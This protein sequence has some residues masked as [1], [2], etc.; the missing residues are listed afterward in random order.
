[1]DENGAIRSWNTQAEKIFGWPRK[2]VLGKDL[3]DLIV[4][5][6]DQGR[7]E[8]GAGNASSIPDRALIL[9]RR[10]ETPGAAARRQGV[11]GRTQRHRAEDAQRIPVQR[12]FSADLTE[13]IVAEERESGSS[14]KMEAIG[15]LHRR[16]RA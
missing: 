13:K 8:D 12:I 9:G 11:Q 15:Q 2:E 4:V 1:M 6:A 5:G 14:E 16:H 7:P 10:R 3:I